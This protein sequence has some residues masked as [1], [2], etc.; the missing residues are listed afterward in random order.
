MLD[1]RLLRDEPE[2][3]KQRL[4]ARGAE[5][6]AIVDQV[7]ACDTERRRFETER[8]QLQQAARRRSCWSRQQT[9]HA[10]VHNTITTQ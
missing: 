4:R 2:A 5:Y 3:V 7:L 10:S 8:Q 6:P 9:H 1:I